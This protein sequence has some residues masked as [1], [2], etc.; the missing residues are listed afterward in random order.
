MIDTGLILRALAGDQPIDDI[1]IVNMTP[2]FEGALLVCYEQ[3]NHRMI[4]QT[5]IA[6]FKKGA[7]AWIQMV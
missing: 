1:K 5:K 7:L 6:C 2:T 3:P 4:T